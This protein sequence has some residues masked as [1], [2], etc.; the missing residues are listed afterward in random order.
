MISRALNENWDIYFTGGRSAVAEDTAQIA[1]AIRVRLQFFLTEW[2]LDITAGTPWYESV[3]VKPAN[4]PQIENIIKDR[5][6]QTEGVVNLESFDMS[7]TQ[8]K[9][10][11]IP[12]RTLSITFTYV[13]IFGETVEESI[14]A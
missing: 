1:Q 3:F 12:P 4:I 9:S 8:L 5:I 6:L 11:E 13:D 7:Y 2:F 10:G 14:D